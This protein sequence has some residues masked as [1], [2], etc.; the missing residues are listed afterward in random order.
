[1]SFLN[2]AEKEEEKKKSARGIQNY[3]C[4]FR[5][6]MVSAGSIKRS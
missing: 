6:A 4:L 2:T 3:T 5:S 1:M